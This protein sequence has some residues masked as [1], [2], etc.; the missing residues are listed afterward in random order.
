M[1]RDKI[2]SDIRNTEYA[3]TMKNVQFFISN[4]FLCS[5]LLIQNI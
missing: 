4:N 1:V 2:D 5:K 3:F